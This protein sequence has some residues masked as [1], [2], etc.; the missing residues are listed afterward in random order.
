MGEEQRNG[1][2]AMPVTLEKARVNIFNI[3][4]F[5]V[6]LVSSGVT[7]GILYNS[8]NNADDN[9]VRAITSLSKQVD[10]LK[11]Q[12]PQL[13][14]MQAQITR[15]M[16]LNAENKTGVAET[17]KRV[18]RVVESFGG[19]LDGLVDGVN[20]IATRVEVLSSQM[21]DRT[22]KTQFPILRGK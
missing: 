5:G 1:G 18:D 17:N 6:V 10:E 15:A 8:M 4:G 7:W 2:D 11:G 13:Q 19:K 16:E 12:M 3:V 20:K 14:L 22:Q 9:A 21:Q